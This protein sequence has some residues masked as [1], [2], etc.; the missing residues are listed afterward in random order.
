[1]PRLILAEPRVL[2]T[3]HTISQWSTAVSPIPSGVQPILEVG[4]L[5]GRIDATHATHISISGYVYGPA[6]T[7]ALI[8]PQVSVGQDPELGWVDIDGGALLID[9]FGQSFSEWAALP[10][11]FLGSCIYIRLAW[12]GGDNATSNVAVLNVKVHV[13]HEL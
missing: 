2:T 12:S 5:F 11:E 4:N 6:N 8:L 1:M 13:R 7:G 9:T 10:T 3:D